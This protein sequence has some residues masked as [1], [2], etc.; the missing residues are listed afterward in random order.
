M[1]EDGFA[2]ACKVAVGVVMAHLRASFDCDLV[3]GLCCNTGMHQS[4]CTAVGAAIVLSEMRK[5]EGGGLAACRP[6]LLAPS[7]Y[8]RPGKR[9]GDLVMVV[10]M[11]AS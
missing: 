4:A 10:G 3:L 11:H 2:A 6:F 7:H 5:P 9:F 8:G 1:Q